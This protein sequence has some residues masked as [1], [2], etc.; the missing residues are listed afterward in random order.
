MDCYLRRAIKHVTLGYIG[1]VVHETMCQIA[2]LSLTKH[3]KHILVLQLSVDFIQIQILKLA[4]CHFYKNTNCYFD[5]C[6]E[7]SLYNACMAL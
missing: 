5:Y 6:L 7:V 4:N 1:R 2:L 3:L